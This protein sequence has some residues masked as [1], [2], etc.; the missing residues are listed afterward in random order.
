MFIILCS[1]YT[2][3]PSGIYKNT[4]YNN[5]LSQHE[6][7]SQFNFIFNLL[8]EEI[9]K[10]CYQPTNDNILDITQFMKIFATILTPS[11]VVQFQK[12]I[13]IKQSESPQI[14]WFDKL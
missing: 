13:W 5:H 9:V 6:Y 10:Y 7:H 4:R 12:M 3:G 14:P 2:Q 8:P 11:M 1:L